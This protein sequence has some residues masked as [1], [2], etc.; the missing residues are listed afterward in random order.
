VYSLGMEQVDVLRRM[1]IKDIVRQRDKILSAN[2]KKT[3]EKA[4]IK[5][6]RNHFEMVKSDYFR[7]YCG[8]SLKKRIV[9]TLEEMEA[10]NIV[11]R[12]S[13]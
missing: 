8:K 1:L 6:L 5:K 13:W 9:K 10:L 3:E 7:H 12:R 11:Q 2:L 4:K